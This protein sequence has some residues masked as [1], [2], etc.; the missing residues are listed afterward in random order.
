M[1]KIE[2]QVCAE[3]QSE[4]Q[5]V[6]CGACAY[7]CCKTCVK[8]YLLACVDDPHCM[9][10]KRRMN[11]GELT[12]TFSATFVNTTFKEW[13]KRVLFQRE[14][15]KMPST[16]PYVRQE[17]KR[18]E[19]LLL[20]RDMERERAQLRQRLRELD[21]VLLTLHTQLTPPLEDRRSAFVHRCAQADCRGF[22]S[23]AWKCNVCSKYTCAHCNEAL[24]FARDGGDHVCAESNKETMR[25]L[26]SDSKN[27]PG[28]GECIHRISG[29]DQMW[30]TMCA[31]AFSW[32]TGLV[33]NGE[34]IHN[35]HFYDY[36]QRHNGRVA[37]NPADI[38]CG[39]MPTYREIVHA[40]G[41]AHTLST[42]D[43]EYL[44]AM[45]RLV[46]HVREDEMRRYELNRR[47]EED[48]NVDL[49]VL[50]TLN[51]LDEDKFCMKLQQREK[52]QEK[53]QDIFD[54]LQLIV[55]V[56]S[57]SL[58]EA[59]LSCDFTTC[60]QSMGALFE[61]ANETLQKV[62]RMYACVVPQINV[63]S[64]TITTERANR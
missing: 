58:R 11:R 59:V 50:Y 45:H 44:L 52:C 25:M 57:D 14:L 38:P 35:P 34:Q 42:K 1:K 28:C 17:L 10:C 49:R 20:M 21:S 3:P 7:S 4:R 61:Y 39:G 32:R 51:E 29:C 13:R 19:N 60:V 9:N 30:C 16:Q 6:T 40:M 31:T 15:A 27:C 54:V 24:G 41:K 5:F 12:K 47:T 53:R 64:L 2:C 37:R 33:V 8:R 26:R 62:S 43:C 63:Q 56:S 23:T 36:M 18:R 22:L 46:L 55:Q 48:R